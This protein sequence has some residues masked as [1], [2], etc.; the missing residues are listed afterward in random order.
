MLQWGGDGGVVSTTQSLQADETDAVRLEDSLVKL[1][2]SH[3]V[4]VVHRF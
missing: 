4:T 3:L 2:H 1:G